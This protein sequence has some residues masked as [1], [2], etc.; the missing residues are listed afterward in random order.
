MGYQHALY[1]GTLP[2]INLGSIL[3]ASS[4]VKS[5]PGYCMIIYDCDKC[6]QGIK[7]KFAT[8]VSIKVNEIG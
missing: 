6:K 3:I 5:P 8:E 1:R 4:L 7:E 2:F